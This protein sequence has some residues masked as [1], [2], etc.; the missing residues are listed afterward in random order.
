MFLFQCNPF[1]I[2]PLQRKLTQ[3]PPL[4]QSELRVHPV[5]FNKK[6]IKLQ[7]YEIMEFMDYLTNINVKL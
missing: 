5:N 6:D 1:E 7:L 3:T 2:L 4:E